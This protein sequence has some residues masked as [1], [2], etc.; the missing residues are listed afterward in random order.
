MTKNRELIEDARY[1]DE[2]S[3]MGKIGISNEGKWADKPGNNRDETYIDETRNR[4][5][6]VK[7]SC[8]LQH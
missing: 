7:Y 4:V 6:I 3:L 1:G 5:S 2:G 8:M